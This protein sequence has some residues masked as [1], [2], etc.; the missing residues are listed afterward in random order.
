MRLFKTKWFSRFA[1]KEHI[2]DKALIDAVR[3]LERGLNDGELGGRLVKKRVA[4]TGHGKR[5]GYRTILVYRAASRS[6]FLFGF[7]K[8]AKANL[9]V[10]E[11]N[12]YRKL[13]KIYLDFSD[14]DMEKACENGEVEEI[15]Y[16]I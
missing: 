16:I 10:A 8:S 3:E 4:R 12:V 15:N 11:L 6:V 9:S 14:A 5:G 1:R 7:P 2:D 13:A